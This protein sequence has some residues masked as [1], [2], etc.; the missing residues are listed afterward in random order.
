MKE[1]CEDNLYAPSS[2]HISVKN[3]VVGTGI[4]YIEAAGLRCKQHCWE[5]HIGTLIHTNIRGNNLE[6]LHTSLVHLYGV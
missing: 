4:D 1:W 2:Y 3:G 6:A 5:I